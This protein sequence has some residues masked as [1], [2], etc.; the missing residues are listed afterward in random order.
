MTS[1]AIASG[2]GGAGKTSVSAALARYLGSSAVLADCDV[3]AANA[4][5]AMG[6][7]ELSRSDYP[8]GDGYVI[9]SSR[10]T[11]CGECALTCRFG[12]I[13]SGSGAFRIDEPLCERCGLCQ[14]VCPSAALITEQKH[15]GYLALSSTA[16]GSILSHAEL[17]PGEDTSG[18]LVRKVRMQADEQAKQRGA[19]FVLIDAPP[20]I[21]CPVIAS[22]SGVGL[23][24]VV[25][26]AGRSGMSDAARLF[27]LLSDMK[28]PSVVVINKSGLDPEMDKEARQTA[29]DA[30]API[31]AQLP[32]DARFRA[33]TEAGEAWTDA[34]DP[35]VREQAQSLCEAILQRTRSMS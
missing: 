17:V 1:I 18:K 29:E 25:M 31:V 22:L 24:V 28:I 4:L 32:F 9:D 33:S 15:G 10:C 34:A 19:D 8:S 11:G 20:G 6:A 26:E 12:A 16:C 30:R 21:G 27:T 35:W 5:I 7:T 2:K 3:D 14:D 23:A 13:V